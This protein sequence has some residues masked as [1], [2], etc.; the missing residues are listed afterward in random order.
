MS[1][2]RSARL[3][4][5]HP[6]T[7][8]SQTD[9]RRSDETQTRYYPELSLP[10]ALPT[11]GRV[12]VHNHVQPVSADQGCG[13]EGFRFWSQ[14]TSDRLEKCDCG[15]SGLEHY[16]IKRSLVRQAFPG[17]IKAIEAHEAK[18]RRQGKDFFGKR[19]QP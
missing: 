15:W 19:R 12:I 4:S 18:M 7:S 17:W 3:A 14:R 11:N 2:N 9:S 5:G 16:R 1:N 10:R 13:V 8:T 6:S